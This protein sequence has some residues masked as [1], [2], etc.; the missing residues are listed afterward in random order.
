MK[1][2]LPVFAVG[3]DKKKEKKRAGKKRKVKES[4]KWVIFQQ[5]KE[6]TMLARISQKNW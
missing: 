2:C 5:Y 3:D 1:I 4:H 6:Q